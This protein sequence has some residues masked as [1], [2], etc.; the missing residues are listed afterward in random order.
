MATLVVPPGTVFGRWTVIE[1]TRRMPARGRRAML[2]QCECGTEKVLRFSALRAGGTR[3][4]G[5]AQRRG[6][7]IDVPPGTVFGRL[8]VIEEAAARTGARGARGARGYRAML[9][10]CECGKERVV[11]LSNLRKGGVK[12][13]GCAHYGK[14]AD[15]SG[16]KPGEVPLYGK[17]AK[18]RVALVD[19]EDYDLVMQYRWHVDEYE[20]PSRG[21]KHGPYAKTET[22]GPKP[23]ALIRMHTLITGWTLVDHQDHNGLNNR[24][25]N[26][27]DATGTLNAANQHKRSRP[28]SS[29]YKGV[30]WDKRD[31]KWRAQIKDG[32]R[33]RSIGYFRNEED[34]ARAYDAAALAAWG[35]F[36]FLNFPEAC[37]PEALP[38]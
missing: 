18:G 21:T 13:C 35:E 11:L 30:T 38:T 4:C 32:P 8:T 17:K 7:R 19:P 9:C 1:E 29:R 37:S 20:R 22:R 15:L 5:C 6:V 14:K 24:R 36:A 16:L 23:H 26:L 3:S 33:Y 25:S 31:R 28:T 12:S 10:R 27:R 2:C 34:A